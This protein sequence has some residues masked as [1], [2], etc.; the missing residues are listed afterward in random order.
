MTAP[1]P[2]TPQLY[3]ADDLA[4]V[5][6][7]DITDHGINAAVEVG[8]WDVEIKRGEPRVMILYGTGTIG[9]PGG[10][11][12]GGGNSYP[13]RDS[14]NVARPLLDDA[15]IYTLRIHAPG[16][17]S[18][19]DGAARSARKATDA[20]KRAVT[21]A[22]R[23]NLA[24][25]FREPARVR[26]PDDAKYAAFVKGSLC[27]VEIL[28]PSYTLDDAKSVGVGAGT[29]TAVSFVLADGTTTPAETVDS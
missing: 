7:K 3:T 6:R 22:I 13:V 20:L 5:I 8:E 27:E 12:A 23:R 28:I 18:N 1:I 2:A 17:T 16:P 25:P 10:S 24:A 29:S 14:T 4:D 11:Y 26:W 21:G 19:G 15:Q 9:E